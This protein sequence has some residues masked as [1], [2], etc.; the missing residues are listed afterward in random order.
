LFYH[1]GM[2]IKELAL[3]GIRLKRQEL[4]RLEMEIRG[5]GGPQTAAQPRKW[6]MSEEQRKAHGERM[7]KFWAAKKKAAKK[8]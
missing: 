7:R 3:E 1:P 5:S 4:D 6:K 2:D 8:N